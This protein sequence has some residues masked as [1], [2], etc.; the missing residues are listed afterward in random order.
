[1]KKTVFQVTEAI[2]QQ[3]RLTIMANPKMVCSCRSSC[4][5]LPVALVDC[6]MKG[7]ESRLHLVC[8]TGYVD[9]H[10]INLDGEELNIYRN[11]VDELWMGGKPDKLKKVQHSTEY[12]TD[13]LEEDEEEVEGTVLGDGCDEFSIV[14]FVYLCVMVSV[15]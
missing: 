8:Q 4:L 3:R 7:C 14:P 11:C 5:D 13:E 10:E 1:M 2:K 9:M 15:S 12:R 6:Q